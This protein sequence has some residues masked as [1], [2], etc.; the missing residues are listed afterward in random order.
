MHDGVGIWNVLIRT[1]QK[2]GN[3]VE[4]WAG[5]GVTIK[6]ELDSEYQECMDKAGGGD[7]WGDWVGLI[8]LK[9]FIKIKSKYWL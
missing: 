3:K 2:S 8:W 1:L 6:S 9:K 5:G 4:L 7:Y